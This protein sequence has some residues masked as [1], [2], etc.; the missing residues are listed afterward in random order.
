LR[1]LDESLAFLNEGSCALDES[2]ALLM[3]FSRFLMK[4][5]AALDESLAPM[6]VVLRFQMKVLRT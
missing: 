4:G 1:V 6:K 3:K 2:H 5:L